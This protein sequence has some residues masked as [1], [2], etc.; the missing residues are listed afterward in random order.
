[1]R[2]DKIIKEAMALPVRERS[3]L[4]QALWQSLADGGFT[5]DDER[6]AIRDAQQ[7][8]TEL[9][10]KK[11]P[12]RHHSEVIAAVRKSLACR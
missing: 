8:D 6:V 4:A 12:T 7:R 3:T 5:E 1:M 10:E 9:S 11:V 2:S